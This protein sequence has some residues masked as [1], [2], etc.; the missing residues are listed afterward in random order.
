MLP[1]SVF[2]EVSIIIIIATVISAIA[3]LLKQPM[4]IGYIIAGIIV[5]PFF[6]SIEKTTTTVTAFSQL[7]IVLLLFI[8][9]LNLNPLSVRKVGFVSL[10]AGIGQVFFTALLGFII[11][12]LLGFSTITSLY[13]SVALAFSST[14]IVTKLLSDKGDLETLYGR[15]SI[16]ILLVQDLIAI[17]LLILLP[18]F[19]SASGFLDL[20]VGLLGKGVGLLS[21]LFVVSYYILPKIDKFV[22]R[23]QEFLFLF[24]ISWCLAWASFFQI[25]G[26]SIE[27]G[28]LLSGIALSISPYR[29][30]IG[31]KVRP[32]RDFFIVLF[33]I[34]LGT[35][36]HFGSIGNYT[37]VIILSLFVL[38]G[39][40]L[41]IMVLM[42]MLG[43]TKR[44]GFLTGAALAQISEFSLILIVLGVNSGYIPAEVVS[45]V[46]LIG[47]ITIAGSTYLILYSG[48]IYPAISK[49]LS[50]FERKGIKV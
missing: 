17:F 45:I 3:K 38:I 4:I 43:Y 9:G 41:V 30:E 40:P 23:S 15:I 36:L 28:A 49:Y 29:Y 33:F 27:I 24:S 12:M 10:V 50:I 26:F 32:L 31:S 16:G 42:G 22:A 8:V 25:L 11:S 21:L 35:Q 13:I 2:V 1:L 20:A 34:L 48:K 18:S 37:S 19:S 46:T 14:I 5:S 39:N 47:L 44:N 6:L 7:G